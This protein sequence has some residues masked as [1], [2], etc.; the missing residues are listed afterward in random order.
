MAQ[1]TIILPEE[2]KQDLDRQ[3]AEKGLSPDEFARMSIE[4]YLRIHR[5][6]R[7][8]KQS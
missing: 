7:R 2:I 4:R 5:A 6:T 1:M 8:K 3:A